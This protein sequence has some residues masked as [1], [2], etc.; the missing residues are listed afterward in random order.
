MNGDEHDPYP[1]DQSMWDEHDPNRPLLFAEDII[2]DKR[3]QPRRL[4]TSITSARSLYGKNRA[5]PACLMVG[6]KWLSGMC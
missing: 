3:L 4:E 5:C 2:E 6:I 1:E